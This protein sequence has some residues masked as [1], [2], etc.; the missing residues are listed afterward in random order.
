MTDQ[1]QITTKDELRQRIVRLR[2]V[3]DNLLFACE[4]TDQE[5]AIFPQQ[6]QAARQALK[7]QSP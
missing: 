5:Q 4:Q 7:D 3:L 6:M 2:H 1:S